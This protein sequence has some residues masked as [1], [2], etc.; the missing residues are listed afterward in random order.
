MKFS[1][2]WIKIYKMKLKTTKLENIFLKGFKPFVWLL[3]ICFLLYFKSIS[4]GLTDLD[5]DQLVQGN[6][7]FNHNLSNIPKAFTTDAIQNPGDTKIYYRPL[8]TISFMFDSQFGG[9]N[10]SFYHFSNI[11]I[12]ILSVWLLFI[13]LQKL[14]ISRLVSFLLSL[15]FAVH[16]A[17][18]QAVA[19]I[20]GRNDSLLALFSLPSFI[21]FIDYLEKKKKVY[22]F[23]HLLFFLFALLTKETGLIII[24]LVLL[25]LFLEKHRIITRSNVFILFSWSGIFI[26][27]F[28]LRKS[29]L[30]FN[31]SFSFE[32]LTSQ[33]IF[34]FFL[35]TIIYIG[36]IFLPIN[37]SGTPTLR[38]SI[39]WPG[40]VSLILFIAIIFIQKNKINKLMLFGLAFF[41]CSLSQLT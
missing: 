21:F 25:Y 28:L 37:L 38:D 19:W 1:L 27:W 24:P 7:N 41:S 5:D 14:K 13:F 2:S 8:L 17:L 10:P 26:I 29:A 16:P 3:A 6:Y 35:S 4:F 12:H 18:S 40:I 39:L 33:N 20:P 36:K 23:L 34:S 22:V 31:T 32:V 9:S 11:V 15:V 30:G